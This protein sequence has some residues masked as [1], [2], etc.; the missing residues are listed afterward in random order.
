MT[1]LV[2]EDEDPVGCAESSGAEASVVGRVQKHILVGGARAAGEKPVTCT[3][4]QHFITGTGVDLLVTTC[5]DSESF[6]KIYI[7]V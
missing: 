3:A 1:K 4:H 2:A 7:V 5:R 6:I